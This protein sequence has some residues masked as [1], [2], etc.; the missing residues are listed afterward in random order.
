MARSYAALTLTGMSSALTYSRPL[1]SIILWTY[2]LLKSGIN[3]QIPE[4][5]QLFFVKFE[6]PVFCVHANG[7]A[8]ANFAF[9]NIDTEWIENFSLNSAPQRTRAINGIVPFP[10]EQIGR[11]HV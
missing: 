4:F 8:F 5:C 3:A 9:E 11:A 2:L 10:R 1:N 7:L 6:R